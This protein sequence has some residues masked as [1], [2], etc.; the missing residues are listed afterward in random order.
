MQLNENQ[1]S[2]ILY[3][4]SSPEERVDINTLPS[5]LAHLKPNLSEV[6]ESLTTL[7]LIETEK[8]D[9]IYFLTPEGYDKV[10]EI[11]YQN[12]Q[13]K[14]EADPSSKTSVNDGA[15]KIY[16]NLIYLLIFGAIVLVV[17]NFGNK[18]KSDKGD[19]E[20]I[21]IGKTVD[22]LMTPER[23]SKKDSAKN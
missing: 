6:I 17:I 23:E 16:R 2:F 19:I 9:H 10:E 13:A 20:F 1:K 18:P 21:N 15:K 22:S 4:H 14:Q 12:L 5:E 3:I 8:L 7:D 11:E